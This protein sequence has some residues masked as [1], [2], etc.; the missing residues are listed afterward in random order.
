MAGLLVIYAF[1]IPAW[2]MH[3]LLSRHFYAKRRM[4][5]PVVIGTIFTLA[6]IP[7]W[8]S[9]H[10]SRGVEGFA[11]ASTATMVAYAVSMLLAWGSDSGWGAVRALAPAFVKGLVAAAVAGAVGTPIVRAL[12]PDG[13]LSFVTA[14]GVAVAGGVITLVLFAGV[15]AVLRSRELREVT[16]RR[17][18]E[19]PAAD[20][21]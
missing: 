7:L 17:S 16:R 14:V 12:T 19:T 5:V 3:Q 15:S 8:L 20:T 6:A 21:R 18:A 1:S 2:G 13:T 11:L 10:D 9:L 4:W